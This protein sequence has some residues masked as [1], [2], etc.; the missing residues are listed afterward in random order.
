MAY[1]EQSREYTY[2][3]RKR[4][5][6][7]WA[8]QNRKSVKAYYERNKEELQAKARERYHLK[9]LENHLEINLLS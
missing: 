1:N 2:T 5:P 8:A 9:K 6:E 3:Y 4:H 7:K